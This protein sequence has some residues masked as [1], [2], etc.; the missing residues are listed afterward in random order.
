MS[1]GALRPGKVKTSSGQAHRFGGS[2]TD[3]KL[4]V[5]ADYLG[6]YTRALKDKPSKK[7][8]FR[9]G[10]VDAFAGTG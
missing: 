4:A 7:H 6:A 2:W 8:P 10:Y 5:I 9:K 1:E 3:E